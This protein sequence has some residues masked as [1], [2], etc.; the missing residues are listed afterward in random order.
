VS[1]PDDAGP[2]DPASV[3]NDGESLCCYRHP[4]RETG[5]LC[6]R[7]ERPIC[8][9]CMIPA[10]VGFQCPECVAE[11]RKTIRPVKTV[12]G[13]AVRRGGIDATR[14]LIGINVAMFIITAASGAGVLSG[15]GTSSVYD[16]F[17][18]RPPQVAAGEWYRLVSSMF[19]HFGFLH[20]GFNMWALFVIGT[21]LERLL[22]RL[23]FV[24]IYFLAGLGG[25][26]LSFAF[27]PVDEF[28]A[29][30]SGAIFGLFGAFYVVN[31][32]R[33]LETGPIVGLIAINLVFSFTFSGIDWRGHVGGLVVGSLVAAAFVFVPSGPNRD[34][35]QA[36][37]C[38]GIA[39]VLVGS[40]FAAAHHVK[41][42][43]LTSSARV[44][45]YCASAGLPIP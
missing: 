43:C 21:P 27:G 13:G 22:G 15:S 16:R 32:Q 29:G 9:Q 3:G 19:L 36:V 31:R 39:L 45:A 33:G 24:V 28:A 4:D 14:I 37:A 17:A 38:V 34:R 25:G 7:C 26:L 12:Y 42:E 20:I 18:L 23:R 10:S 11:G 6:T 30:A 41:R 44:A 2:G 40:G 8:P 5:V 1:S 35:L